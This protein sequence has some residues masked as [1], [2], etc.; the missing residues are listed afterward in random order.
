MMSGEQHPSCRIHLAS[1]VFLLL[2]VVVQ[3]LVV[4]VCCTMLYVFCCS[5]LLLPLL[6]FFLILVVVLVVVT[7]SLSSFLFLAVAEARHRSTV[8]SESTPDRWAQVGSEVCL[9]KSFLSLEVVYRTVWRLVECALRFDLRIYVV[10]LSH[11]AEFFGVSQR[12]ASD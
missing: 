11:W 4:V 2:Q 1:P 12:A 5:L 10:V 8:H 7:S 9:V 3:D 6:F